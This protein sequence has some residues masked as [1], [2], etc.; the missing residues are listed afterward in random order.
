MK[1]RERVEVLLAIWDDQQ[2]VVL[3]ADA[4]PPGLRKRGPSPGCCTG[5]AVEIFSCFPG[6]SQRI[7]GKQS[8]CRNP[9]GYATS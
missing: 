8:R 2:R 5:E 7:F 9:H 3:A 1:L 4:V 6:A